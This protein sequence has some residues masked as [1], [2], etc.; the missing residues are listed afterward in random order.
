MA[1]EATSATP[2]EIEVVAA[3]E[4]AQ[5]YK[6]RWQ[7]ELLFK[8]INNIWQSKLSFLKVKKRYT[9]S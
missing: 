2:F 6:S 1:E 7:V 4:I 8:H 5:A 3:E 9:I